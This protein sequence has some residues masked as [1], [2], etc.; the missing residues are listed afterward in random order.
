MDQAKARAT[1]LAVR[2]Q[3]EKRAQARIDVIDLEKMKLM[4]DLSSLKDTQKTAWNTGR[5]RGNMCNNYK[6][7][8]VMKTTREKKTP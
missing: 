8:R 4:S 2:R 1:F 7:V 3:E 5:G 6:K